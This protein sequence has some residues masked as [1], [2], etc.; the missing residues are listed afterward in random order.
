MKVIPGDTYWEQDF[1]FPLPCHSGLP[2]MCWT[3]TEFPVKEIQM[4]T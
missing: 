2:R 4:D 1:P 3:H